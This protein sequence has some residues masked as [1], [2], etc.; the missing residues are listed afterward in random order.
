MDKDKAAAL[1]DTHSNKLIADKS[2][3]AQLDSIDLGFDAIHIKQK[4]F[5][6]AHGLT[7]IPI[8]QHPECSNTVKWSIRHQNYP[9]CCSRRC[10]NRMQSSVRIDKR[11]KTNQIKYG[12]NAPA[13]SADIRKKIKKTNVKRYGV[14]Y[15]QVLADKSK[16]AIV[17]KYG[18]ENI[19]MLDACKQKKVESSK[20]KF[21]T[22]HPMQSTTVQLRTKQTLLDR[23]NV[24][25]INQ[26]HIAVKS[27]ELLNDKD[28]LII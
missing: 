27:L 10:A 5:H 23:Y 26:I 16:Q 8:C 25:N 9:N 24:E 2:I 13:S 14:E 11:K 20:R 21:G 3:K 4:L 18:V 19:S 22:T 6:V 7:A 12:G 15:K 1:L 28:F 17:D